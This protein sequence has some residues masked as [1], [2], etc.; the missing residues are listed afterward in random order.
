MTRQPLS[1]RKKLMFSLGVFAVAV[2]LS[3]LFCRV[4]VEDRIVKVVE[5]PSEDSPI[6]RD[7]RVGFV[8]VPGDRDGTH[9]NRLGLRG[10]E[11]AE[12][13]KPGCRRILMLGGSTTY[14]N[15]VTTEQAYPAVAER[16]LRSSSPD[17]CVEVIN[18]GVSGAHS[19]HQLVR[20][21]YLYSSLEPDVVTVYVGWND[22]G[23]YLWERGSWEPESLGTESLVVDV[24]P[25]SLAMLRGSSLARVSY[26]AYKRTMFRRGLMALSS[27]P[28]VAEELA[29]PN[30]ALRR[31]LQSLIELA[32]AGGA[33]VL[34]IK[35]PF[36]LND[37]HVKEETEQIRSM[38]VPGRIEGMIPMV[39]FE[40][41]LPTL[42]AEIYDELAK[43]PGVKT[44]D[45]RPPFR[46]KSLEQRVKLFDDALHPNAEGY[47]MIGACVAE[48]LGP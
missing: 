44:V 9:I 48:A 21:K 28:N 41:S 29:R 17:R 7:D 23:T 6:R 46:A 14:G 43:N 13:K 20:Y 42:V 24:G 34:L 2:L 12:E 10:P 39:S 33:T 15:T 26:S 3:E 27:S 31:H 30:E 4:A 22:F 40:P 18:A 47:A 37:E 38:D 25:V 16:L 8:L 35:F 45:C 11:V 32:H 1:R 5:I 36:V 19:Y